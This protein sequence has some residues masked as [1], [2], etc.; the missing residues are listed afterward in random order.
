MADI[1]EEAGLSVGALY[2]YYPDKE[3]LL[4]AIVKLDRKMEA[5]W[6]R[7]QS[8]NNSTGDVLTAYLD[9]FFFI[10]RDETYRETAMLGARLRI[11][12]ADTDV[13]RVE[14]EAAYTNQIQKLSDI[15]QKTAAQR[16]DGRKMPRSA[17]R[18]NARAIM[19]LLAEA[20]FIDTAKSMKELDQFEEKVRSIV[21]AM[22]VDAV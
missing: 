6:W 5:E 17:A 15:L 14:T 4:L 7:R 13:V 12:A 2:R 11:E 8:E 16:P 21:D 19:G 18:A 9:R 1:A 10:L 3:Q 20:S 22:V